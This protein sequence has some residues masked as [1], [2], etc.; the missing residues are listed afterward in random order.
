MSL[1]YNLLNLSIFILY[2]PR[3]LYRGFRERGYFRSLGMRWGRF[4]G[5]MQERLKN[6]SDVIWIHA[7]SVGEVMSIKVLLRSLKEVFKDKKFVISTVTS[8]GN[9]VAKGISMDEDIVIFSPFD[10][11]FI[12]RR[13][14]NMVRPSL[15]IITETEI[16]PNM[17]AALNAKD[18][19]IVL[20]NGRLSD[21]SFQ[22]YRLVKP[23]LKKI[24]EKIDLVCVQTKRDGERFALLGVSDEKIKQTGNMKFDI[25]VDSSLQ[26]EA[27]ELK[28]HFNL[29]DDELLIVA[30]ST[31]KGEDELIVSVYKDLLEEFPRLKL[32]IAPRH[33]QRALDIA[34]I[35]ARNGLKAIRYSERE[36]PRSLNG[37]YPVKS[38]P[39]QQDADVPLAGRTSN[40]IYILDRIG[41]LMPLYTLACLVLVGGSILPCGGHNPLEPAILKRPVLFGPYMDNFKDIAALF[42]SQGAA[43][44]VKDKEGLK[45]SMTRLLQDKG[46]RDT[47]G[48]RAERVVK[49]NI[50]ATERN[51]D[52]IKE[53]LQ[54]K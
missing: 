48:E 44:M 25:S 32:F 14:I 28:R 16:W 8:T 19:S 12:V 30:G 38:N 53:L 36:T 7:V 54:R 26:E 42:L 13:V 17:I 3:F 34:K 6:V 2:L 31:H 35:A 15:F 27:K 43:I 37:V 22:G 45:D 33:T 18:I 5:N 10:V 46:L 11:S 49:D 52:L 51:I 29:R 9:M 23:L 39:V 47:L 40:G 24:L 41:L 50:G 20:I 1:F 21:S 4:S